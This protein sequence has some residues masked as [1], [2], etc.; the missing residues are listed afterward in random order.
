M[1]CFEP[2]VKDK[3]T[4]KL[5]DS[6]FDTTLAVFDEQNREVVFNDDF[7][8]EK[9]VVILKAKAGK[10]YYIRVAGYDEETGEFT[11]SVQAGAIQSIQGDLNYDGNVNLDDL[12]SLAN[13]WLTGG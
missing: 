8:G 10:R 11:M 3:Y 12:S 2:A 7:W 9:S 6:S 5:Y 1:V 4:I 13:N